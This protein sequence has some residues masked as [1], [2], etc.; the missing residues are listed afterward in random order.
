MT[1]SILFTVRRE[2]YDAIV[3]GT[4]TIEVRKATPR[5]LTVLNQA[6]YRRTEDHEPAVAVFMCGKGRIHRRYVTNVSSAESASAAL[7]REPSKQ[8]R[9]D[10]GDGRVVVFH[11]GQAVQG[12]VK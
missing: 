8:G 11:L 6:N 1:Y 4:K 2:Y 7:G 10:L 5:W 12:G 3:V 9:E